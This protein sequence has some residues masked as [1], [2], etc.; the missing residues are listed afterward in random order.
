LFSIGV[1]SLVSGEDSGVGELQE[2]SVPA[3][4]GD[5]TVPDLKILKTENMTIEFIVKTPLL[6]QKCMVRT[7]TTFLTYL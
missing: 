5:G 3:K 6:N 2:G 7:T 4:Q 1:S